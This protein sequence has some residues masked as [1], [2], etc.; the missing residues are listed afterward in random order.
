MNLAGQLDLS[1]MEMVEGIKNFIESSDIKENDKV[2][3]LADTRSDAASLSAVCMV[4]K[5]IGAIPTVMIMDHLARYRTVPPEA[6]PAAKEA[7]CFVLVWPVFMTSALNQIRQARTATSDVDPSTGVP[8]QP[9]L[10]YLEA[11]PGMFTSEYARYPNKL[12]WAIG[13]KVKAVVG[14][15]HEIHVECPLGS[16]LTSTYD[17]SK[18]YAMQTRPVE[19]G[20]RS[21]FPWGRCGV[22]HGAGMADGV[23]YMS[24]IQGIPGVLDP[25]MKVT[26]Q[27][28]LVVSVEGG[29]AATHV[30]SIM[31]RSKDI[32]PLVFDEIMFGF[33]PKAPQWLADQDYMHWPHNS[34]A[35]WVGMGGASETWS[36]ISPDGGVF[37]ASV[38]IDGEPVMD[39][40]RMLLLQDPELRAL[41][42]EYGDPYELLDSPV[43]HAM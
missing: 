39:E 24:C 16:D 42:A 22:F 20:G 7:D 30:R 38:W 17:P 4:L 34:K 2:F 31:D 10:V 23:V 14:R 21:H 8:G 6:L 43:S 12:L 40:G 33:H 27:E 36:R 35:V 11:A 19:P 25:P 3:L 13:E 26:V 18:L 29:E 28:N 32:K 5:V 1:Q 15:G 41:A 9:K 37:R